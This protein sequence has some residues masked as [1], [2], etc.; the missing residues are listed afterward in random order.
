MFRT[1]K[2][3]RNTIRGMQLL[4]ADLEPDMKSPDFSHFKLEH[5]GYIGLPYPQ[6]HEHLQL[7][8]AFGEPRNRSYN[9]YEYLRPHK[10]SKWYRCKRYKKVGKPITL[11][12]R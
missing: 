3:T 2:S 12:G 10:T 8:V 7:S 9:T 6:N 1:K 11:R 5:S 4:L